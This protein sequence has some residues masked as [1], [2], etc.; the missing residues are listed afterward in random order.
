MN[1]FKW[2]IILLYITL[3]SA[4]VVAETLPSIEGTWNCKVEST[5]FLSEH[6]NGKNV[7]LKKGNNFNEG[8]VVNGFFGCVIR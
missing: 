4:N 6:G 2:I 7:R 1:L 5:Y 8:D 3:C